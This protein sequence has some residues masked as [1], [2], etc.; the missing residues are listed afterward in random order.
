MNEEDM[1]LDVANANN[2]PE[3]EAEKDKRK[4]YHAKLSVKRRKLTMGFHNGRLQVLPV[5]WRF[6]RMTGKQLV[7]NWFAGNTEEKIPLYALLKF[8]HAKHIKML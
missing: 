1:S 8:N 7:E 5:Y 3:I 6:P 4:Q 2:D